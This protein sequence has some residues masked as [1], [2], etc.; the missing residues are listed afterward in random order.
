MCISAAT[1][2]PRSMMLNGII[3]DAVKVGNAL[4]ARLLR[5]RIYLPTYT[6]MTYT[7]TH[8]STHTHARTHTCAHI[9]MRTHTCARTHTCTYTHTHARTHTRASTHT[10]V[11][12]FVRKLGQCYIYN[13]VLLYSVL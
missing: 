3:T 1:G 8:V 12:L 2:T 10:H 6:H 9:H 4:Y 11:K 7:Y 13:A 5:I